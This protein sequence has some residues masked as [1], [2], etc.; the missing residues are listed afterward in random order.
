MRR[1]TGTRILSALLSAALV[2]GLLVPA[3]AAAAEV[4]VTGSV[5]AAVRLDY[6]Q[7]LDELQER[8]V[9]VTLKKGGQS[10]GE[11]SLTQEGTYTLGGYQARVALKNT[12]GGELGGGNWPGFLEVSFE[13]LPQGNY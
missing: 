6:A 1:K 2:S 4:G 3:P 10:L 7:R 8:N 12:D 9:K 11:V 5:T 13:G